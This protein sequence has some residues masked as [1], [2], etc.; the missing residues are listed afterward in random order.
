MDEDY[1]RFQASL[2]SDRRTVL[3]RPSKRHLAGVET[4][5]CQ[6]RNGTLSASKRTFVKTKK[7]TPPI[8]NGMLFHSIKLYFRDCCASLNGLRS[9]YIKRVESSTS[10]IVK[11]SKPFF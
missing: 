11:N 7:A 8:T 6:R 2:E 4:A 9:K 3:L 10:V 1:I 5:L